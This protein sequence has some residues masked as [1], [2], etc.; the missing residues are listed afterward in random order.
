MAARFNWSLR[1]LF[2]VGIC[3]GVF[4]RAYAYDDPYKAV[5]KH[6]EK[7]YNA[8]KS[9]VP[10]LG[11]A[12]FVLK[13]WH[14]AGVKNIKVALF[15]NQDLRPRQGG[16]DF[17]SVVTNSAG[18]DWHALARVYSRQK[19]EWTYIYYTDSGKD[20][21]ILVASLDPQ[22]AVVAQ[23]RFNVDQL[24]KFVQNPE[25]LG[26]KLAED[27]RKGPTQDGG[28]ST[29]PVIASA[30]QGDDSGQGNTVTSSNS[31]SE[32]PQTRKSEPPTLIRADDREN[33]D[34]EYKA[35]D[36][37]T[38]APPAP[39]PL[40]AGVPGE[41]V[42]KLETRLVN[43]NIQAVDRSGRPVT[44]LTKDDFEVLENGD[45]ENITYFSPNTS[46]VN[47][48]LLLDLSGST[49]DKMK[50]MKAAAERF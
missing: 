43:L 6:I 12:N 44:G 20:M 32:E 14:P 34:P 46:P 3:L 45:K 21:R 2:V 5:V 39:N 47:V 48:L 28:G 36:F 37:A 17:N 35:V 41:R 13:F 4:A 18:G 19:G 50:T 40:P 31:R 9:G 27:I 26:V 8:K 49:K 42:I 7:D 10:F 22:N 29:Q 25:L 38:P 1:A 30:I 33:K 11:L 24:A 15:D 23:V 16:P